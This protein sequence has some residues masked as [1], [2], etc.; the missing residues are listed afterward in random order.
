MASPAL[1]FQITTWL[2]IGKRANIPKTG[3]FGIGTPAALTRLHRQKAAAVAQKYWSWP[4]GIL[5]QAPVF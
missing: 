1:V 5:P 2:M 4:D 3:I